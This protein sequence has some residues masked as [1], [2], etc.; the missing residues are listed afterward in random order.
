MIIEDN[1]CPS[2]LS[3]FTVPTNGKLNFYCCSCGKPITL[4]PS[5][6]D[7]NVFHVKNLP[8]QEIQPRQKNDLSSNTS[9]DGNTNILLEELRLH[10][11][12]HEE[13][14]NLIIKERN[15]YLKLGSLTF[16]ATLLWL[17]LALYIGTFKDVWNSIA[18]VVFVTGT[19]FL[20]S[21]ASYF[22]Y[23][24]SEDS[25]TS[26]RDELEDNKTKKIINEQITKLN[27][28][29]QEQQK[30]VDSMGNAMIGARAEQKQQAKQRI[31]EIK[32]KIRDL[33]SRLP[34]V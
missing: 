19:I 22:F 18:T 33:N 25:V 15:L 8:E 27:V 10:Q 28:E 23:A 14:K 34:R 26:I 7:N 17:F 9:K 6:D 12:W 16:Y 13:R 3:P 30:I 31:G 29:M 20:I 32:Q 24:G 21:L 5:A 2:C 4:E 11:Q 1:R